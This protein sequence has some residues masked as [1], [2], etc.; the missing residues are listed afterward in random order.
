MRSTQS[1]QRV[2]WMPCEE[3]DTWSRRDSAALGV[4]VAWQGLVNIPREPQVKVSKSIRTADVGDCAVQ[5]G[6]LRTFPHRQAQT[7]SPAGLMPAAP[8]SF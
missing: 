3:T 4:A 7:S 6:V 5:G 2:G 1:A 8:E